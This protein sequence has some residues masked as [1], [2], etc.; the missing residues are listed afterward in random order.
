MVPF[1]FGHLLRPWIG[2]WAERNR[3]LLTVTDRSSILLV[4]YTAFSAEVIN[5]VWNQVPPV[6][7]AFTMW[8]VAI[9]LITGLLSNMMTPSLLGFDREDRIA[10]MFCGSQTP[11]S[12]TSWCDC[13]SGRQM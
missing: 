9:L 3:H 1:L 4:V 11:S 8:V 6:V 13:P 5:G 7:M 10:V 12:W 2:Q